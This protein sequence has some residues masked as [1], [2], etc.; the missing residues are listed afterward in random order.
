MLFFFVTDQDNAMENAIKITFPQT[1]HRL[2]RWHMLKK[3]KD[4]LKQMYDQ[5]PD[6]KPKLISVINHPL[7]PADFECA[8]QEMLDTFKLHERSA[9]Q[10]L[11]NDRKRWITCY[12]KEV[13]CGTMQS[14]QRSESMHSLLK[15]GYVDNSSSIHEF[16]K[17]FYEQL[18]HMHEQESKATYHSQVS[19]IAEIKKY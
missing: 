9:L 5:Q 16:A 4:S 11:Y 1:H 10:A 12:F 3:Y 18:L 14:T 8:W 13:F 7:R 6:L 2:C 17:A 19:T 15:S